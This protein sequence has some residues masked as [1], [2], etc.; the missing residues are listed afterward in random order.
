[1]LGGVEDDFRQ[2]LQPFGFFGLAVTSV[3][4]MR[5]VAQLLRRTSDGTTIRRV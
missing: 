3:I 4:Q 1:V 5:V 2:M